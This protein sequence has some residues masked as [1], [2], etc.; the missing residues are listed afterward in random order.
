MNKFFF[1]K[2]HK[3]GNYDIYLFNKKIYS[4]IHWK[5]YNLDYGIID[6]NTYTMINGHLNKN[7]NRNEFNKIS[8]IYPVYYTHNNHNTFYK[9][10][11]RYNSYSNEVKEK[12]NLIF[13]DDGSKFP[14]NLPENNLNITLLRIN[15]D[16]P[17]NQSGARNL[18]ACYA[19]DETLI[20][21]DADW[22][23][24][25]KTFI[26]YS[27]IDI[28]DNEIIPLPWTESLSIQAKRVLPNLFIIK[29]Q[30][31]FHINCYDEDYCGIYGDDLFFRK[32]IFSKNIKV[33][34]FDVPV[35]PHGE[36]IHNNSH[37]LHRNT[38]SIRKKLCKNYKLKH[39]KKILNFPW[40]VTEQ[41]N[42]KPIEHSTD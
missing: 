38:T 33:R 26:F 16:K 22:F 8:I 41:N 4:G 1:K 3:S 10:I 28:Y 27:Q 32:Y 11:D 34:I 17:W 36:Y 24:P 7:Y 35:L 2:V 9:L 12:L 37:N 6:Y 30:T 40:T 25:E 21:M 15:I 13:I 31:F 23:M 19:S 18:G 5:Y 29:K 42:F 39:S 20:M 14:L